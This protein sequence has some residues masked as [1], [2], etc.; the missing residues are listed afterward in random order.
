MKDHRAFDGEYNNMKMAFEIIEVH[1]NYVL[2]IMYY[3]L[4]IMYYVLCIMYYVLCIMYYVLM[5]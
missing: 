2:C 3:V 1:S 4:C 5:I